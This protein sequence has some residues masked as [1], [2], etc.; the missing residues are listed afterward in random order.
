[1]TNPD[2]RLLERAREY[3]PQA[4]AAIY[5]AY[6]EPIYRYLYRF[7]GDAAQAEDLT[8]E[9][10]TKLL[11][12]LNTRRAPCEKL[13][14]WLYRVAHNLAVDW[15]RKQAR[16]VHTSLQEELIS[17]GAS[18]AA[19]VE[20]RL[21]LQQ[22]RAAIAQLTPDQQRVIL[23]RFGE[24]YKIAEVAH[25]MGK[26]VGAVKVLQHRAVKRLRKLLDREEV[27]L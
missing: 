26:S 8:S 16:Q 15:W 27:I 22:L 1:L 14:G 4:L 7:V 25:L 20:T 23:L 9:V 19:V 5:D 3:D 2:S 13:Q 12:V 6:A 10:F 18:P 11:Q 24:G 21:V 17:D